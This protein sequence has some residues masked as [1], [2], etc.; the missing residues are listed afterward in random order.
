M[1]KSKTFVGFFKDETGCDA[2][3]INPAWSKRW[4]C[5]SKYVNNSINGVA[6]VIALFYRKNWKKEITYKI[7]RVL[8]NT[9]DGSKY[10]EFSD[11][12]KELFEVCAFM[13]LNFLEI[14]DICSSRMKASRI[15]YDENR[16]NFYSHNFMP[17]EEML[18]DKNLAATVLAA[19][20]K[21]GFQYFVSKESIP[22]EEVDCCIEMYSKA[23][24]VKKEK[25]EEKLGCF[26]QKYR[27]NIIKNLSAQ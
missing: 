7:P 15:D 27:E 16:L 26:E 19:V 11:K 2:V 22:K 25:L 13:N 8:K 6:R 24:N 21:L 18:K 23:F 14:K 12:D 10:I 20:S 17:D 1:G 5:A 3:Y 4:R 9:K